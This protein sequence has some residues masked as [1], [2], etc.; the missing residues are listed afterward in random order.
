MRDLRY[1]SGYHGVC[2]E[3]VGESRPFGAGPVAKRLRLCEHSMV[4]L[5][6]FLV[7]AADR[8]LPHLG[9]ADCRHLV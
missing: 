8:D 2:V 6:H 4:P 7:T 3:H 5:H 1:C 9:Y